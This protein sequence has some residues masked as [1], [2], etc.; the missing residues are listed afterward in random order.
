MARAL[1]LLAMIGL[2]VYAVADI[3]SSDDE[4]RLGVPRLPWVLVALVPFVGPITW[5]LVRRSQRARRAGGG[6]GGT[7]PGPSGRPGPGRGGPVAPDDDPEFLW[8][9]EQERLRRE[10]ETRGPRPDEDRPPR[11]GDQPQQP[12]GDLPGD[13]RG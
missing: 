10:R 13:A 7:A 5:I 11:R 3:V 12:D 4:D 6:G 9:L 2:T 1:L 8:R